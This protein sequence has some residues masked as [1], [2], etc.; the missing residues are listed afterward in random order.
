M[1]VRL[2]L[3][4]LLLLLAACQSTRVERD[5]DPARDFGAYR[6]WSWQEPAVQFR[7]NDPRLDSSLTEQR[8]RAAVADQLEQR[9]LRQAPPGSVG[10][11]KVQAWMIVDQRHTQVTNYSGGYWGN[12][13]NPYWGMPSYSETRT[14]DYQVGTLLINLLDG[15]DGKLVWR[16]SAEKVVRRGNASPEERTQAI[17]EA[18]ARVL[19]LYPPR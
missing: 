7:P 8:V 13:W 3:L 19:S 6:S 5:F 9:G 14:F 16:G 11:L 10:D 15:H 12:P 4:P 17:R 2:L 18:V 1:S